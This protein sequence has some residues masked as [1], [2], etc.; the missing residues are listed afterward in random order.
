[1]VFL[2]IK[3]IIGFDDEF[4]RVLPIIFGFDVQLSGSPRRLAAMQFYN[5]SIMLL[6][7]SLIYDTIETYF[8]ITR[9]RGIFLPVSG[10]ENADG[11][12]L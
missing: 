12:I 10:Q 4:M 3:I 7:P 5:M 1:M 8:F 6:C 2:F 11:K 9:L